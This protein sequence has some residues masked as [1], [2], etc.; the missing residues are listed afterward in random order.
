MKTANS[1]IVESFISEIKDAHH[2]IHL[3]YRS[4]DSMGI[5]FAAHK[6]VPSLFIMGVDEKWQSMANKI[7]KSPADEKNKDFF[8][9]TAEYLHHTNTFE[10]NFYSELHQTTI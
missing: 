5:A 10:E 4:K 7:S 3:A 1:K 2:R 6:I 9:W 8:Q